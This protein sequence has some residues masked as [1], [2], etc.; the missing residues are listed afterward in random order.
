MI[1]LIQ[2]YQIF[3]K[4]YTYCIRFSSHRKRLLFQLWKWGT[5]PL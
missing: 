3:W 1:A 5:L 2:F 4:K